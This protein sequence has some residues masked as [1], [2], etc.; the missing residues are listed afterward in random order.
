LEEF[1][2]DYTTSISSSW[3]LE[4]LNHGVVP[5]KIREREKCSRIYK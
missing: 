3:P 5:F 2:G 1:Q 4:K